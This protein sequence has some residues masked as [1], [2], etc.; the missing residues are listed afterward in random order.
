MVG[1]TLYV[2]LENLAEKYIPYGTHKLLHVNSRQVWTT[3]MVDL[4]ESG[5]VRKKTSILTKCAVNWEAL[6]IQRIS[7]QN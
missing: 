6:L 2:T 1:Q 4:I 7:I 3:L 5:A